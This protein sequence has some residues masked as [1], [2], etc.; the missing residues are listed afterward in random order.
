MSKV[1]SSG[2]ELSKYTIGTDPKKI[3]VNVTGFFSFICIDVGKHLWNLSQNYLLFLE[4]DFCSQLL[5][6][7]VLR[8]FRYG[9]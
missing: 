1:K 2:F 3:N 7:V 5:E 6:F 4:N 8:Q 9:F